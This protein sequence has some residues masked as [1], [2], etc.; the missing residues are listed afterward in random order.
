MI[1][2]DRLFLR[3][4]QKED[5]EPFADMYANPIVTRY[6]GDGSVYDREDTIAKR[7]EALNKPS[8]V[9]E[10]GF[11]VFSVLDKGTNQYLGYCGIRKIPD[12]RVELLYGYDTHAW[13]KGYATEAARAVLSYGKEHFA[14]GA[15]NGTKIIAMSYPQNTGSLRVIE[16]LGFKPIGKEEHFGKMLD[17]FEMDIMEWL[18][19]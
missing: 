10:S 16:K 12:G 14:F 15:E 18:L 19:G 7:T 9:W 4:V 8:P 3:K 2:T 6:L 11:G 13:G 5:I 1:T 17:V